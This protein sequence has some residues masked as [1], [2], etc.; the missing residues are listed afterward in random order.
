M[1]DYD[2]QLI[3]QAWLDGELAAPEAARFEQR[4][5]KDPEAQALVAELQTTKGALAGFEAG[6]KLP[7]SP[8]LFWSNIQRRIELEP[9]EVGAAGRA[10]WFTR[11]RPKPK[12]A[13]AGASRFQGYRWASLLAGWRAWVAPAGAIAAGIVAVLQLAQSGQAPHIETALADSGAFTYYDFP[14]RTTLV[15]LSYPADE[16]PAPDQDPDTLE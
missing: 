7:E 9:R 13:D 10:S 12:P 8:E 2:S 11:W 16:Q 1:M 6:V 3:L 15:W 14:A 5:A 4:L